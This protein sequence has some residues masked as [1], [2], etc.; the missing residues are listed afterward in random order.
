MDKNFRQFLE[1]IMV[2]KKIFCMGVQKTQYRKH[3]VRTGSDSVNI[4]FLASSRQFRWLEIYLV[5]NKS[6][7]HT[8]LYD[9]YNGELAAKY[10]KL[11]KLSN[12]KI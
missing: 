1:A 10:I 4:D 3:E 8:S 11:V 6:N 7:K 9:S 5:F 2:S 12:N